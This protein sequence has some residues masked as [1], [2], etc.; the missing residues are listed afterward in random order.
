MD[1]KRGNFPRFF[2]LSMCS[3]APAFLGTDR[4]SAA[5]FSAGIFRTVMEQ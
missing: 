3:S 5:A 4:R 1:L 2:F